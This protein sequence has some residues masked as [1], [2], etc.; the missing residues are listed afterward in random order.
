[1]LRGFGVSGVQDFLPV[2]NK[3]K[4]IDRLAEEFKSEGISKK[5][6]ANAVEAAAIELEHYHGDVRHYGEQI[7]ERIKQ[8]GEHA[9][10]LV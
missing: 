8:T 10:L 1:M 2:N 5:E 6:V 9:I 3:D 4:L 7:I